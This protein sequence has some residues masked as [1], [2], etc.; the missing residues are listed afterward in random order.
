MDLN[1]IRNNKDRENY[2]INIFDKVSSICIKD[3]ES[4][5]VSDEEKEC[6]KKNALKLHY[7]INDSRLD[8]WVV[9]DD[10]RPYEEYYWHRSKI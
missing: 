7:I 2:F 9:N 8:R 1:E 5:H 4:N 6:L 10:K 3:T